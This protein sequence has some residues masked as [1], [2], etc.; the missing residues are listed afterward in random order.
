MFIQQRCHILP[1]VVGQGLEMMHDI[2]SSLF[3]VV[4][5]TC[6]HS[7]NE[8]GLG[9]EALQNGRGGG[10]GKFYPYKK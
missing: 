1:Y 6:L 7:V 5:P 2:E 10:Q 4:S 8:G 9:L 3:Y